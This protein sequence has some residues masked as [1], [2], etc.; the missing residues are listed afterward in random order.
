VGADTGRAEP[1]SDAGLTELAQ[2]L[3]IRL[4][5][6]GLRIATAE[7]C[8]GGWIA[9]ALTDIP[10]S[11]AWFD[12]AA[13]SYSNSLK[14]ALLGIP[15]ALIAE[16]GAVSEA[17]ARSMAT[18]LR[19]LSSAPL[20]IAVTGIAGPGGGSPGKPVG[21][22]WFAWRIDSEVAAAARVFGGNRDAV[23]R[24]SVQFAL[25]QMLLLLAAD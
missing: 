7:S 6:R 5:A 8:T 20:G 12:G 14:S 21:L 11:S 23:R 13:V 2:R 17:V 3:G 18:G 10:G 16:Q 22:V 9:K 4:E 1:P 15:A 24:Q 19:Q 25:E